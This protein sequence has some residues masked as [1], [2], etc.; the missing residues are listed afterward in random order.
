[1]IARER[2]SK[3]N[4]DRA[5][6]AR[7]VRVD[8]VQAELSDKSLKQP[9]LGALAE[10]MSAPV[11]RDP[12]SK[13]VPVV[14]QRSSGRS[15]GNSESPVLDR[16]MRRAA[17]KNTPG[18]SPAPSPLFEFA[19]LQS[20]PDAHLLDVAKD[21]CVLFRPE[22]G[23]PG[24]VVSMLKAKELA[25]AQLALTR[26]KLEREAQEKQRKEHEEKEIANSAP[27]APKGSGQAPPLRT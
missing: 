24:E 21:S 7:A 12:R 22:V 18:N 16:A 23:T 10:A 27:S 3:S 2:R 5:S 15:R 1:M 26:E 14:A 17:D 13:A 25:Q 20:I 6:R 4:A 19:V 11:A 8:A 9:A